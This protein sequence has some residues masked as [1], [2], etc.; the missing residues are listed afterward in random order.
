MSRSF[1]IERL[2]DDPEFTVYQV[3]NWQ[4]TR[5]KDGRGYWAW[6]PPVEEMFP[7]TMSTI[8]EGLRVAQRQ[9]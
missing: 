9:P 6:A 8:R 2:F 3:G 4:L 7:K 1:Q 5:L